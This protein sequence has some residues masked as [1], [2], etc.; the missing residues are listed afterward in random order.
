MAM[1]RKGEGWMTQQFVDDGLVD[2]GTRGCVDETGRNL[3]VDNL[4][5]D[6]R[7]R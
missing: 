5:G 3:V 4:A 1:Q 2:V 6:S 7:S